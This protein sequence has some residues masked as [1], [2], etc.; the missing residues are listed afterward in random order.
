M[1]TSPGRHDLVGEL[2]L[3][4]LDCLR[5]LITTTDAYSSQVSTNSCLTQSF[6]RTHPRRLYRDH[7]ES[8][9]VSS[10]P[11]FFR[12]ILTMCPLLDTDS[13]KCVGSP[14]PRLLLTIPSTPNP[15]TMSRSHEQWSMVGNSLSSDPST[16]LDTTRLYPTYLRC[17]RRPKLSPDP[18]PGLS[19][20]FY[21]QG[22]FLGNGKKI[23]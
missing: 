17:C 16:H 2:H 14:L 18:S 3:P 10:A 15:T 20:R 23:E 7:A 6:I 4:L 13:S 12:D 21:R 5:V 19:G 22:S 9:M 11:S 1:I 8:S